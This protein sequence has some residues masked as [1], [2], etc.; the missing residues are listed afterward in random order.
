ME[1]G[2][3]GEHALLG[4]HLSQE[5][6][7]PPWVPLPTPKSPTPRG[8]ALCS[9]GASEQTLRAQPRGSGEGKKGGEEER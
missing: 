6:E 1:P 3:P 8:P 5:P 7:P 4:P 9:Q 2:H